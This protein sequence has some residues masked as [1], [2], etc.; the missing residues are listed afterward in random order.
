MIPYLKSPQNP[1]MK[2]LFSLMLLCM[3]LCSFSQSKT[4]PKFGNI[5]VEDFNVQSALNDSSA[6]AIVLFDVASSDFLGNSSGDFSLI[7]KHRKRLFI[8]KR[9]AFDDATVNI[10]LYN[11]GNNANSELISDL[12]A[13][14][15]TIVDGKVIESKLNSKDL[16]TEKENNFYTNKKFT[17]PSIAEGCI[18][19]YE[20]TIRSPFYSRLKSWIFQGEHPVLWSEYT[21]TIPHIF[22][23]LISN[24][25]YLPYT[26]NK[27][28]RKYRTYNLQ[29]PSNNAYDSPKYISLSGDAVTATW[30]IENIPAFKPESY[31]STARNHLSRIQFQL[32][33]IKYSETNITSVVK[34]WYKTATDLLQDETFGKSLTES[35]DFLKDELNKLDDKDSLTKAKNVYAF[36]R[37]HF[38]CNDFD[39]KWLSQTLKKTYQTKVGN[40]ADINLLLC[41][42]LNKAGFKVAPVLLST[43]DNG[44]AEEGLALLSQYNYVIVKLKIAESV[45]YLDASRPKLGFA[46][47]TPDCYNGYARLIDELPVLVKLE[48]DSI[49]DANLVS[50]TLLN[51]SSNFMSG[52]Y[53]K[54]LGKYSSLSLRNNLGNKKQE[55]IGKELSQGLPS[56]F[57]CSN[58]TIDSLQ[59]YEEP[60]QITYDVKLKEDDLDQ[61]IIYFNPMLSEGIKKNPFVSAERK[62]P[63]EMPYCLNE[64]YLFS[65]QIPKGYVVDEIPKST[66][67][68][69]FETEGGFEYIIN[70]KDNQIMLRSR[71]YFNK[72]T[73]LPDDYEVLRDFFSFIVKKHAEQ[74]V[75]KKVS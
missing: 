31:V 53:Y 57:S 72:A 60:I 51:D 16:L 10:A 39:D 33:A 24:Y 44:K 23:Y 3:S 21:V 8:K 41:A 30:A 36:I 70:K 47:L 5:S 61:D 40:V 46:S 32:M 14:T 55:E 50:I 64:T 45:Y 34:D 56:S 13:S 52:R 42:M 20:Y 66:R 54:K 67:V 15:F 6:E 48:P 69:F 38:T 7:F 9:T 2:C 37:D 27:S 12:H 49:M 73:F 35:N 74:I 29:A 68:N 75:F 43:T 62:Y 19:E 22:D 26:V 1:V 17:F 28:S 4:I 58:F 71:L 25:G 63:V 59:Q 18:I 65:M 11:G